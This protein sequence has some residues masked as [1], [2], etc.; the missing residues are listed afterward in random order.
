MLRRAVIDSSPLINLVHLGLAPAL[1]IYFDV[2]FVPRAVQ[3]E[4]NKKS[5]F[6]YRLKKLYASGVFRPC[7]IA[8]ESSVRLL[9]SYAIH[10]GEAE[11]LAQAQE[12]GVNIFIGDEK[13][14]RAIGENMG[15]KPVGTA[16]IIARM[17]LES[18]AEVPRRLIRKLRKDLHFRIADEVVDDAIARAP[19]PI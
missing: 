9:V 3:S 1:D 15:M 14:A 7:A 11:A 18:F 19:E 12:R 10:E 17:H 5:R 4:V 6:R 13:R 16:R 8:D 2:V